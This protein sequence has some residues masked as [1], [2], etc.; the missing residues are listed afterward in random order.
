MK[1]I[2]LLNDNEFREGTRAETLK[3][4]P[5][6]TLDDFMNDEC[7]ATA[8]ER[9]GISEHPQNVSNDNVDWGAVFKAMNI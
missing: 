8:Q 7:C 6:A 5:I 2:E 1:G 3:Y 4:K 9:V